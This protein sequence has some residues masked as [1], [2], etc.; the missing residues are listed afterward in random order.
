MQTNTSAAPS[1]LW[2]NSLID[3]ETHIDT[4]LETIALIRNEH[5]KALQNFD[6]AANEGEHMQRK[7]ETFQRKTPNFTGNKKN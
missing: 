5:K 7:L 3:D 1:V 6:E 4:I 2:A